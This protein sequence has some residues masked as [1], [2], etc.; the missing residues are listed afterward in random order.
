MT[1]WMQDVYSNKKPPLQAFLRGRLLLSWRSITYHYPNPF[2]FTV[3][4]CS[5]ESYFLWFFSV[6]IIRQ[7]FLKKIFHNDYSVRFKSVFRWTNLMFSKNCSEINSIR[8]R[9]PHPYLW[10]VVVRVY[11][12]L[13]KNHV[14]SFPNAWWEICDVIWAS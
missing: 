5:A 8:Q 12:F 14:C 3:C 13:K 7:L 10:H 1:H 9:K 4:I 2:L 6:N 11:K